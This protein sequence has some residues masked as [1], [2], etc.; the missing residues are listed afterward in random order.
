MDIHNQIT[1]DGSVTREGKKLEAFTLKLST[2]EDPKARIKIKKA[3]G[4]G[5]AYFDNQAGWLVLSTLTDRTDVE[6]TAEGHAYSTKCE[7]TITLKLV[8]GN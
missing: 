3:I 7:Q 2:K 6:G 5:Q 4:K 1:Y 8:D